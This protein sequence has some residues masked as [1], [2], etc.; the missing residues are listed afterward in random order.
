M[1]GH[2][3]F[4]PLFPFIKTGAI[5]CSNCQHIFKPKQLDEPVKTSYN[6]LK[7]QSKTPLWTFSGLAILAA[8][9]VIGTIAD[10][11]SEE[12]T[13]KY[14]Q[15]PHAGDIMEIKSSDTSYTLY[16]IGLVEGDSV[17]VYP[18]LYETSAERGLSQLKEKGDSVYEEALYGFSKTELKQMLAKGEI[19]KINR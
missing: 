16:K 5:Q 19:L 4:I 6:N 8:L 18:N 13:T 9:I 14:V 1:Y 12:L 10:K 3:M 15:Q 2:V 11:K 17:Y 7:R